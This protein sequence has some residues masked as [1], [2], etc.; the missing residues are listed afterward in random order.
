MRQE[1]SA[2]GIV[3]KKGEG[4]LKIAFILDPFRKW[5]F[6][7]GHLEEGE[8]LEEAALRETREEMGLKNLK[9]I[10]PLGKTDIWFRD[11]W[12]HKG[13][14]VHKTIHHFLM[15]AP[16]DAVAHPQT[17][18]KIRKVRW[19]PIGKAV[20]FCG[21]KNILGVLGKAVVILGGHQKSQTPMTNAQ[22]NFKSRIINH[23]SK[24][25]K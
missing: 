1:I 9:I 25:Q 18:E 6:A 11:R 14:M 13:A 12:Q 7:K 16:R 20:S 4:G 19:V 23:K 8:T 10:A 21:Y 24:I 3:Y 2:G 15:R 5:T 22:S 17:A